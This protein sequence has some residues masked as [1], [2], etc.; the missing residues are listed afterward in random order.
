MINKFDERLDPTRVKPVR[1]WQ[2]KYGKRGK[3]GITILEVMKDNQTLDSLV[4]NA[5]ASGLAAVEKASHK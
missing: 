4:E 5:L 1:A 2:G 3:F